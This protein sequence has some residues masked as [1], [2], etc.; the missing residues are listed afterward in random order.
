MTFMQRTAHHAATVQLT[1]N[2]TGI[3]LTYNYLLPVKQEEIMP[4]TQSSQVA[5]GA[6][7]QELW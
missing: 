3:F 6:R 4:G 5:N 1:L 7:H 2:F